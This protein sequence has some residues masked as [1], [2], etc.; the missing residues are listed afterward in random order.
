MTRKPKSGTRNCWT[1]WF[2]H[3]DPRECVMKMAKNS[4]WNYC[5]HPAREYK[6]SCIPAKAG[7]REG[8][9]R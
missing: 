5:G 4:G 9:L 8:I 3:V 2:R 1:Q 7:A 6:S